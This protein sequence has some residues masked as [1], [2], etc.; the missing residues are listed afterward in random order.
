M[1]IIK[2]LVAA[3]ALSSLALSTPAM[4]HEWKP[5]KELSFAVNYGPGGTADAVARMLGAAMEKT[6]GQPV[7]VVNRPGG[8]GTLGP[9]YI[10][11]QAPDGY[12]LGLLTYAPAAIA[13]HLM[14]VPYTIDDFTIIAGVGRYRYGI[15]VRADSPYQ[16]L[17][18]LVAAAKDKGV[19]FSATGTPNNLALF[20]LGRTT[21]GKFEFVPY[22]SGPESTTAV[23]AGQVDAVVQNPADIMP[24]VKDGRL[25]L[26]ASASP[27]RWDDMPDVP[28]MIESGYNV[29]ID[30]WLG[31]AAPAG[32]SDDKLAV[33]Q[34]AVLE[35]AQTDE[36][37]NHMKS[38][39]VEPTA[40]PGAEYDKILREGYEVMGRAIREANIPRVTQ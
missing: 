19:F 18:D 6:I 37:K 7:V 2:T 25:R 30:S 39:G 9:A 5:T 23:L 4:A 38:L 13:P 36:Y 16:T 21:G 33:L 29:S 34:A 11:R 32:L 24:F 3:A 12:N 40:L 15:A 31:V 17:D 20:E 1:K 10:A 35:A 14:D 22:K 27:V 26:I 8:G 28:T